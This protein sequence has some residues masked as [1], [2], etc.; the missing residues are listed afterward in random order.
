MKI[1]F[2]GVQLTDWANYPAQN[3]SVNGQL[4]A[5]AIEIVRAATK[6][7]FTRGN[8]SGSLQFSARREF[9]THQE[10]QTYLLSH[11]SLLPEVALCE[12]VCG[13]PGETPESVFMPN[14]ILS[15]TPQGSFNGV[16]VIV[17]Y[18]I[19]F[20]IVT[21]DAPPEFL[22]APGG[23]LIKLGKE[24]IGN[25]AESGAV[26]FD[27]AFPVGTTVVVT[28]TVA[29]P[30]GS[31]SNIFATIRDDLVTIN[32]FTYELDGPTPDA[33]HKLNWIASGV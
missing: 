2:G 6:R 13:A 26:I 28:A 10:A 23:T 33:N 3:V 22:I 9:D 12:V 7:F 21:A 11:F 20:G 17:Q 32:G 18:T 31:G 29:K 19:E 25:A 15:A 5:E 30:S 1:Y 8:K 4:V 14:A 27:E 16:E 24:A